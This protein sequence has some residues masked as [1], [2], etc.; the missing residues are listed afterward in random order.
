MKTVCPTVQTKLRS[1]QFEMHF[2]FCPESHVPASS[3]RTHVAVSSTVFL[4]EAQLWEIWCRHAENDILE[5][6]QRP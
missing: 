6:E 1:D 4:I 5:A 3:E 2:T